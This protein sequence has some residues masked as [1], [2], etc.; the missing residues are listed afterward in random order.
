MKKMQAAVGVREQTKSEIIC[1]IDKLR[2]AFRVLGKKMVNE[3]IIP[4]ED[5]LYHL[6]QYE[7]RQLITSRNPI[8]VT[9]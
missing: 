6:T 5:L 1:A 3:G 7:I 9:K 4:K 8:L 2:Q